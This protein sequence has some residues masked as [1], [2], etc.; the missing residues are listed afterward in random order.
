MAGSDPDVKENGLSKCCELPRTCT[1][2]EVDTIK[3]FNNGNINLPNGETLFSRKNTSM[4]APYFF[5]YGDD[6]N[7]SASFKYHPILNSLYGNATF[8][9]SRYILQYCGTH[10][11]FWTEQGTNFTEYSGIP[12]LD[13]LG[14]ELVDD[15][16]AR[17][18][19]ELESIRFES[20]CRYKVFILSSRN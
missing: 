15:E 13:D 11:Y 19:I 6:I 14:V 12:T 8:N 7:A 16:A 3:V 2:A 17:N 4:K 5:E 18:S 1:K 10:G 20:N 9:G